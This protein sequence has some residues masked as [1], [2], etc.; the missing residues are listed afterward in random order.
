MNALRI[1]L[2]Q[3]DK[4]ILQRELRC[5]F[6][7]IVS[8]LEDTY[9]V[10]LYLLQFLFL[11]LLCLRCLVHF[12]LHL[13]ILLI[14][15]ILHF[16]LVVSFLALF[17]LLLFV[18]LLFLQDYVTQFLDK[19]LLVFVVFD[20]FL[21]ILVQ[22]LEHSFIFE[23][24]LKSFILA[25]EAYSEE[26]IPLHII[27]I[28]TGVLRLNSHNRAFDFR[29]RLEIIPADFDQMIHSSQQLNI[30]AQPTVKIRSRFG[31]KSLCELLL[32]HK[33]SAPE[34]R[35]VRQ[36]FEDE[37]WTDLIRNVGYADIEEWQLY[38][39][40][41]AGNQYKLM[42]VFRV[43]ESFSQL[44]YH[45]GIH[46]YGDDF[47]SPLQQ[48][49]GEIAGTGTNLQHNISGSDGRFLYHFLQDMGINE[50]VLAVS[51]VENHTSPRNSLLLNHPNC[52]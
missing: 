43:L 7:S 45:T 3:Q 17:L 52:W 36:E 31:D 9:N 33:D 10:S 41:I 34:S 40:N 23:C 2:R 30:D 48:Q 49:L 50:N 38:S 42:L 39:H 12:L 44:W 24:G 16:L 19:L 18:F 28:R 14:T 37:R 5:P 32:K 13:I 1:Q 25:D 26:S 21:V 46:F 20:E 27:N 15:F 22:H 8:S 47:F 35:L 51:F 4:K 29:W 11:L 6:S